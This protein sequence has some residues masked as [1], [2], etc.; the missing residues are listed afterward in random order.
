MVNPFFIILPLYIYPSPGAW[1]QI[2]ASISANPAINFSIIINP[3]S[4]P[5]SK[6][7][8]DSNY[9]AAISQL[10]SYHN[11]QLLGYVHSSNG[12]RSL[13]SVEADINTY[14]NWA[15]Y[16][17]DDIHL[18]GIFLDEAPAEYSSTTLNY[19]RAV[20]QYVK[21]TTGKGGGSNNF[22]HVTANPGVIVNKRFYQYADTINVFEDFYSEYTPTTL[23]TF[24][25]AYR[26]Q[27]SVMIHNFSG[28]LAQQK[29]LV[30]SLIRGGVAGL[31]I[32]NGGIN[33]NTV[34]TIWSQF[35]SDMRLLA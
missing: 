13:S 21:N 11:T 8:P 25:P 9:I 33:Y 7:Y 3:D 2:F 15:S 28:T 20:Y 22:Q 34:S 31:F 26:S 5:G 30:Q 23:Q 1:S 35:C 27:S 19:M 6:A 17:G 16:K 4:G 18:D 12:Q 24:L 14:R 32:S 10:N 29:A